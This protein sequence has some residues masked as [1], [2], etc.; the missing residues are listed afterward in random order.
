[1]IKENEERAGEQETDGQTNRDRKTDDFPSR[2]GGKSNKLR[3]GK[4]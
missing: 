1:M 4:K 2:L 3:F